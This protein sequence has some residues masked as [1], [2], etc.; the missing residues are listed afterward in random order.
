MCR[1]MSE[2]LYAEVISNNFEV[3]R[4]LLDP[5]FAGNELAIINSTA[6]ARLTVLGDY[7]QH[8]EDVKAEMVRL[9]V[10]S[11]ASTNDIG[12]DACA[13]V[14]AMNGKQW[15]EAKD[16][17]VLLLNCGADP[18]WGNGKPLRWAVRFAQP[19]FV[20]TLLQ[21]G[22]DPTLID[23]NGETAY[24]LGQASEKPAIRALFP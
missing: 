11:G 15:V 4:N 13:L 20:A 3:V 17:F 23:E 21:Y 18:N 24:H 16:V 22:A 14:P 12:D 10:A 5:H 1:G 9:L 2:Q 7:L 8:G 6:T 19:E